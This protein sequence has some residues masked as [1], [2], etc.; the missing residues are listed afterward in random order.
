MHNPLRIYLDTCCYN[1]PY[2]IQ[3]ELQVIMETLSKLQIQK[4]IKD[5]TLELVGSQILRYECS[6]NPSPIRQYTIWKFIEENMK[7]FVGKERI[8]VLK[9]KVVEL[10][11]IG[12]KEY[13][14][15]HVASAIYAGCDYFIS[16]DKRLLKHQISEI[17]IISPI[18]F[19]IEITNNGGIK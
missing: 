10:M 17:K 11:K 6:N 8:G 5:G 15:Y 9:P 7:C 19:I 13:D 18:N 12:I 3:N 16:V 4:L 14:A 2:D 1:R